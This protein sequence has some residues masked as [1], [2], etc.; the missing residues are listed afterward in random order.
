MIKRTVTWFKSVFSI[1]RW[2]LNPFQ[3]YDIVMLLAVAIT[4]V[5]AGA[6]PGS[7][8]KDLDYQTLAALAICNIAGSLIALFGL[9][10]RELESALW[11]ELCGYLALI[12]VMIVYLSLLF[13]NQLNA[14]AT[15]GFGF[16]EAFVFAAIQ[17]SVQIALYKRARGRHFRLA[18][19]EVDLLRNTLVKISPPNPPRP[20]IG[21]DESL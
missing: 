6:S 18:Q 11:I 20:V 17:R 3:M 9:H 7:V 12:F 14:T 4:Q 1:Q 2:M 5:L 15:Y 21:E 19:Q 10:L 8:Q 16:G 13:T